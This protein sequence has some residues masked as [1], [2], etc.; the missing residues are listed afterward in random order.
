MG[1]GGFNETDVNVF[2]N[3]WNTMTIDA[4]EECITNGA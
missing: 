3:I 4:R 1:G 2:N